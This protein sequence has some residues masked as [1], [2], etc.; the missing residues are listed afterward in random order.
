MTASASGSDAA[1]EAMHGENRP[2]QVLE[3]LQE[4][5][6]RRLILLRKPATSQ[7]Q[8]A[9]EC[10]DEP[11]LWLAPLRGQTMER[12]SDR[13]DFLQTGVVALLEARLLICV[14]S[15]RQLAAQGGKM[16]PQA[17]GAAPQAGRHGL[18][19]RGW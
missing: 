12:E 18:Q 11:N 6:E 4:G 19:R 9:G 10:A 14:V 2:L 8:A 17:I 15:R 7:G 3:R 1:G 5:G 16:L 13:A